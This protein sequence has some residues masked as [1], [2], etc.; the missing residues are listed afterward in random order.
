MRASKPPDPA[1]RRTLQLLGGA[2]LGA[3]VPARSANAAVIARRPIPR[4][5]ELLPAIGMGS[6]IT[7]N[8]APFTSAREQRV[9]VLR[10]FFGNGGTLIDSS[11]MYGLSEATIGHCLEQLEYPSTLFSATKVWIVSR[12]AGI[13]Q[14]N[15]SAALWGVPRFDLMQIHNMV[16]WETHLQTLREWRADGR[17]RYI[18]ITTSHGRRHEAMEAVIKQQGDFDFVQF[19]Y[20]L[21]D[22]EAER[23]LLPAAAANGKAVIVNRPFRTGELIEQVRGRPLPPWAGEIGC[24]TWPQFLLKFVISHPAVTCAIP[25]TSRVDHMHE[26]MQALTGP[27]PDAAMRR[28]MIEYF[29]R[30]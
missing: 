11:P 6:W 5:G 19:S 29:E 9:E 27:L 24:R 17:V 26:N 18:G 25:A 4:S 23:R 3:A 8:V 15:A 21:G 10:A 30:G 2:L 13:G 12:L 22:R 14:M 1:R 20:S 7:F 28:R 16:D